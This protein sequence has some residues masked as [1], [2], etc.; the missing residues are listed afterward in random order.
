MCSRG[1]HA[2]TTAEMKKPSTSAHHTAQAISPASFSASRRTSTTTHEPRDRGHQL[3][4][5][6]RL[7]VG[8]GPR[9][10]V[11]GVVVEQAQRDLVKRRL[12]GRDLGQDVDAVA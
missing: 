2:C 1:T 9:D 10:A 5:P 12:D 11:L 3:V 6:L 8:G 4:G 7:L